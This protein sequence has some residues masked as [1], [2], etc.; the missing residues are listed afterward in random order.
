MPQEAPISIMPSS[1]MLITP[2]RS[3]IIP[4][5]AAEQQ[6]RRV[7]ERR[8]H[9]RRPGEH[10]LQVGVD[11]DVRRGDGA[12]D[13]EQRP[14]H[15]RF[16][17]DLA[18]AAGDRP[19]A[20]QHRECGEH[21][22]RHHAANLD[23]R[24]RDHPRE[25]AEDHARDADVLRRRGARGRDGDR[26]DAHCAPPS[27]AVLAPA[28]ERRRGS[29]AR[30]FRIRSVITSVETSSMIIPWI[31]NVRYWTS[32]GIDAQVEVAIRRAGEERPEQQRGERPCR[33]GVAAEQRHRDPVEADL[34][35]LDVVR[36]QVELPAEDVE[37]GRHAGERAADQHDANPGSADVH[38]GVARCLRVE[39]DRASLVAEPRAVD[40]QP[41]H[42]RERERDEDPDVEPLE[43]APR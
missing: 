23:R 26:A 5:S 43:R 12:G 40:Q 36:E 22:R 32:V 19:R 7:T 20:G 1:P 35:G 3:E 6:R 13:R 39:A 41:E 28:L 38:P 31:M 11:A 29:A 4:P 9:Q 34:R 24:E 17:P 2:L 18:L 21:D 8:R 30:P 37:R 25:R 16:D 27:V 14:T 42:D 33:R 10:D 15:D